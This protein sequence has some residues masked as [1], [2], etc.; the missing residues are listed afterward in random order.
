[1]AGTLAERQSDWGRA[2]RQFELAIGRNDQNWYSHLELAVALANQGKPAAAVR[3]LQRASA[4][5]PGESLI[6]DSLSAVRAGRRIDARLLDR[7]IIA[8]TP[9]DVA[10]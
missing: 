5:D 6:T 9:A 10:R 8:R 4:L 1:V 3:E 2:A 7:E